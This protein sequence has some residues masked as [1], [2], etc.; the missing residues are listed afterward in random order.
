M[1]LHEYWD[2]D[3]GLEAAKKGDISI[4]MI[5]AAAWELL[6]PKMECKILIHTGY[7]WMFRLW[8]VDHLSL[9]LLA[10]FRFQLVAANGSSCMSK[11]YP[12]CNRHV[13]IIQNGFPLVKKTIKSQASPSVEVYFLSL[14]HFHRLLLVI[15]HIISIHSCDNINPEALF[16]SNLLPWCWFCMVLLCFAVCLDKNDWCFAAGQFVPTWPNS[17]PRKVSHLPNQPPPGS[18]VALVELVSMAARDLTKHWRPQYPMS[19]WQ[20]DPVH[21]EKQKYQKLQWYLVYP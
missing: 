12:G 14:F 1:H 2:D 17:H 18:L 3:G 15:N 13:P 4:S 9:K 20:C 8:E 16:F 10:A 7:V 5:L 11:I 19:H 21:L 6:C